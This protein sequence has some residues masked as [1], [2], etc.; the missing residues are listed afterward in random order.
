MNNVAQ[1]WYEGFLDGMAL[2]DGAWDP[3]VA[4]PSVN[5]PV[6][7]IFALALANM[8]DEDSAPAAGVTVGLGAMLSTVGTPDHRILERRR[9]SRI[10]NL[11]RASVAPSPCAT[12]EPDGT[13]PE[14]TAR[15][16]RLPCG[17]STATDRHPRL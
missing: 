1:A 12:F 6:T 17:T 11:R 9:T 5:A 14:P 13:A 2:D 8:F 7:P 4:N 3:L 10:P 16:R 15:T